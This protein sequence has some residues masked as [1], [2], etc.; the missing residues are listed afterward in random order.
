VLL[1]VQ[2][3]ENDTHVISIIDV[4]FSSALT[5]V[6]LQWHK[7]IRVSHIPELSKNKG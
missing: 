3:Q 7:I 5:S 2:L 6:V 4:P 1:L